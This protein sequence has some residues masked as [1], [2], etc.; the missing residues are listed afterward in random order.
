MSENYKVHKAWIKEVEFEVLIIEIPSS[1]IE[2]KLAYFARDKGNIT[3]SFYEDFV[4]ATCVANINQLLYHIK[5]CV[6]S[7]LD[8]L[9]IREE[10]MS[11]VVKVNPL[12][13]P[14]NLVINRNSVVKLKSDNTNEDE[15][16]LT[17]NKNWSVSY[18]EEDVDTGT[19]DTQ[20]TS[21]DKK[22]PPNELKK[23]DELS[24]TVVKKWWKRINR[25]VEIKQ[26]NE[27]D[28]TS[29]ISQRFFHNRSSFQTYVVTVCVIDSDDLFVILDEMGVPSRVA[30]HTLMHEV[31]ELCRDVNPFLTFE[32]AQD[33]TSVDNQDAPDCDCEKQTPK[34]PSKMVS[35]AKQN[36]GNKKKKKKVFKDVPKEEL[37]KLA[38][39][40]KVFVIGQDAAVDQLV[41]SIQ[42]A[43]V[44]LKDPEK[45]I[46][47]FI[48][49][50]RTGCGKCVEKDT[51]IFSGHGIKPIDSFCGG[52][53]ISELHVPVYGIDGVNTT[54]HIY[55]EGVKPG[56]RVT[57][58]N[59]YTLGGSLVHPIVVLDTYGHVRFK[60]FHELTTDDYVA[61]QYGQD[62][63]SSANKRL[64]YTFD[65]K[66]HDSGSKIYKLPT[67]V[68]QEFAYWLGLLIGDGGLSIDRRIGFTS[69]DKQLV[70]SFRD[71][72]ERLFGAHIK[73]TSGTYGYEIS[74]RHIYDFLEKGCGIDM[75]KSPLKEIPSIILES[76]KECVSSFISG[77]MDTDGYFEHNS[78]GV[79]ITLASEK[80]I[81]QLS[82]VLLNFGIVSSVRHRLVRYN[83]GFN[84]AWEL[85]IL[86]PYAKKFF[87]EI[88][89]RL[90]C[91][92][93]KYNLIYNKANNPNKDI[94]PNIGGVIHELVSTYT[95]NRKFHDKYLGYYNEKRYPGRK[96][97]NTMLD[98]LYNIVGDRIDSDMNYKYLRTIAAEKIFWSKIAKIEEVKEMELYDFTVPVTH[99]FTSNGFISHN[100][101]A[102]KVLADE[103][104]KDRNNLVT[105]DCSEY[106]ADHEYSK[107]IGAASGYVGYEQGGILTNAI[108]ENPFSVVVFDE[109]EKASHK[110]HELMLQILDEGRLTDNKGNKVSFKDAVIIMT[111]NIGVTEVEDVSK[112]IGFGDVSKLTEDKKTKAIDSAIKKK[113]KPEFINRID[114]I[115]HFNSLSKNDYARI[116]D[117]ELYRLNENLKTNDTEFKTLR[118]EF[119]KKVRSYIYKHG[120]NEDFG[121]RPLKRCIEKEVAT[122]LANRLL[123][124]KIKPESVVSVTVRKGK[125]AF[126]IVESLPE[127]GEGG[128]VS[129]SVK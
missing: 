70:S 98:D 91:K 108:L 113:F 11:E 62:Y 34:N 101:L 29:V 2:D 23:I 38:D 102:S 119:D 110:V 79:G 46:G 109:I 128:L 56:R 92:K 90:N 5:Q 121:A 66:T 51:L 86:G 41:E 112:T 43:S 7:N 26:F 15:R 97:L 105:I 9:K 13:D 19:E 100:T 73:E 111:S 35:H 57:T 22:K 10:V 89:F 54:S 68:S 115:V 50:G 12:L 36:Q 53:I 127:V 116:I 77:L 88:N 84:N 120:I 114:S 96:R 39:V 80:L 1:E 76:T 24:T 45:P 47:S 125:V 87:K 99:T 52:E 55:K 42:R 59:G 28:M 78:G 123:R 20:K 126:D 122:P 14:V 21:S 71:L 8:M 37:L 6:D 75:V 49:A 31:Y 17:E 48:F 95:L 118:L 58:N 69:K 85:K 25:Y 60:E 64:E 124:G 82:T 4:I 61:I 33:I 44:G 27:E 107:L 117:I 93:D 72:S 30:P 18:Y 129:L 40:M 67:E 83:G 65:K 81:R 103:L 74:S 3:K 106:S 104:I 32:N 94:I 63:F 16:P